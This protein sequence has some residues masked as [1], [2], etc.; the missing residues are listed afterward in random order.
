MTTESNL[1]WVEELRRIDQTLDGE[2]VGVPRPST[3]RA[4][5]PAD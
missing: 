5:N 3:S 2:M 1:D 4:I